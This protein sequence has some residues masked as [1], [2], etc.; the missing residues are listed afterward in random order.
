MLK[1]YTS[2]Q[3][4]KRVMKVDTVMSGPETTVSADSPQWRVIGSCLFAFDK[5]VLHALH[6]RIGTVP[7]PTATLCRVAPRGVAVSKSMNLF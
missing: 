3:G 1:R 7:D 6:L 5:V 2:R 4:L